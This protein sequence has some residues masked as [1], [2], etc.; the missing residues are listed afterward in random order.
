MK[1]LLFVSLIALT[2][3]AEAQPHVVEPDPNNGRPMLLAGLDGGLEVPILVH[4]TTD[5]D[6]FITPS[7][8]NASLYFKSGFY[9]V[10]L[11]SFYKH[12][13]QCK[14]AGL[15]SNTAT[16]RLPQFSQLC[17]LVGYKLRH[18]EVDTI[19]KRFK[20]TMSELID[21]EGNA[22]ISSIQGSGTWMK[23]EDFESGTH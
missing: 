18:Y 6:L 7:A 20:V 2:V 11:Y 9:V 15:F 21:I 3:S 19:G 12:G 10:Y 16:L 22:D 1:I 5:V 8:L 13:Y 14:S 4:S 17:Q 23:F